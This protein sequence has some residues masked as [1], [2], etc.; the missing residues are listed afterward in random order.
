MKVTHARDF[1][2][3]L[4]F[5]ALGLAFAVGA[6]NYALGTAQR[7]GPAYFPTILGGLLAV[8]GIY[9]AARGLRERAVDADGEVPRF[10]F[11]PL[12]LVLGAVLLFAVTLRPLGLVVALTALIVV[13]ALGG[14]NFKLKEVIVITLV[15]V[16]LV[17]AVFIWGLGLTIPVWPAFIQR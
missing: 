16:L 3:G 5:L 6:Q 9:I 8:L 7:M 10:H 11:R 15:M 12:L 4:L 1:W 17:L 2:A 13:G 14:P